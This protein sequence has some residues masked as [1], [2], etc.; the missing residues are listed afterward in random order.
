MLSDSTKVHSSHA[1][2][3]RRKLLQASMALQNATGVQ[4]LGVLYYKMFKDAHGS[5]LL[6]TIN[7]IKKSDCGSKLTTMK[8]VPISKLQKK[9]NS[10]QE[11]IVPQRLIPSLQDQVTYQR[12]SKLP[13][14]R[15]LYLG[16]LKLR[17]TVDALSIVVPEN[18][19]NMLPHVKIRDIPSVT[20]ED[21]LWIHSLGSGLE[22]KLESTP[23]GVA[24]ESK[25]KAAAQKLFSNLGIDDEYANCHRIYDKEVIEL[26]ENVLIILI[27]PP[28]DDMC[29][30]PG[31]SDLFHALSS[32]MSIPIQ[33]FELINT[34]TFQP[35]IMRTYARA[36]SILEMETFVCLQSVREALSPSESKLAKERQA[37]I[38]G[39]Q[40]DV[41][42]QWHNA[43]WVL[44]V[45]QLARDKN[46]NC[47][48]MVGCLYDSE[49]IYKE[50]SVESPISKRSIEPN[51]SP[52]AP[53]WSSNEPRNGIK[54]INSL[55]KVYGTQ[56]IGVFDNEFVEILV[57][58]ETTVHEIILLASQNILKY[59][60][61]PSRSFFE[62]SSD[63]SSFLGLVVVSGAKER[64]LRDDLKLLSLQN[65]WEKG[66]IFLRLK[67]EA[68]KAA[69]LSKSTSV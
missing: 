65:P 7:D 9:S 19:P 43:R 44:D 12:R 17:T 32:Y 53:N 6:L 62:S 21:W 68:Y 56:E 61:E 48:V 14:S 45:V 59:V 67:K 8:W 3:I 50:P 33:T 5:I 1:I 52:S 47:G 51:N 66:E 16:Y 40:Q 41:D 25:L 37:S 39:F 69:K 35:D 63:R 55:I 42:T 29:T 46:C 23:S 2:Q 22:Q 38:N 4:D 30:I 27:L 49:Y 15:G 54:S 18:H 20:K 13:I 60:K 26:N 57:T 10:L 31:Q 64:C 36:S 11:S 34:N 28:V 24:F 58:K